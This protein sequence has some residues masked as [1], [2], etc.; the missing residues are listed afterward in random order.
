LIYTKRLLFAGLISVLLSCSAYGADRAPTDVVH[1]FFGKDD[2]SGKK[3]WFG[4]EIEITP[5]GPKTIG[6]ALPPNAKVALRP[7]QE[8]SDQA[9][10][11]V[12]L[13][14]KG[15]KLDWY[16][17]LSR[18]SGDWQLEAVRALVL[19]GFIGVL[20]AD[21]KG[22]KQRTPE[23]ELRFRNL[24]LTFQS[25]EQLKNYFTT[26]RA[27]LEAIKDHYIAQGD[28]NSLA[29]KTKELF[30]DGV[31]TN[32]NGCVEITIGGFM[33]NFV[34]F[35]FVPDGKSPPVIDR[36]LYIMIDQI[37]ARWYLFKTT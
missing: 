9:V 36:S 6:Q 15:D 29:E 34:G 30:V 1:A 2:V 16:A 26:H 35:M 17:Y 19:P 28:D 10:Y 24:D 33:D 12:L 18:K 27:K 4:G 7:L 21:L 5:A 13:D 3:D 20:Y 32:E 23:E 37:A 11:A 31:Q 22:K 25:D 14:I 8:S